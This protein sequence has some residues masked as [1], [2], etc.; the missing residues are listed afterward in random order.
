MAGSTPERFDIMPKFIIKPRN[1]DDEI[2]ALIKR[3]PTTCR[4]IAK[5]LGMDVIK[6][7][8]RMKEIQSHYGNISTSWRTYGDG[9]GTPAQ[10]LVYSWT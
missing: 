9:K 4:V 8:K 5:K 6:V 2:V 10:E 7:M 3:E 1:R